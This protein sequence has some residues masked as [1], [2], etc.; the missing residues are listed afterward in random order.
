MTFD[1]DQRTGDHRQAFPRV[2]AYGLVPGPSPEAAMVLL[3][4]AKRKR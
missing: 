2:N 3:A 1:L 4:E